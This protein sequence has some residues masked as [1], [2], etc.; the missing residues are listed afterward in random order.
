M[1]QKHPLPA[2]T[3]FSGGSPLPARSVAQRTP[4]CERCV[5][6]QGGHSYADEAGRWREVF[7]GGPSDAF[8][9][10]STLKNDC[11]LCKRSLP[12]VVHR[13]SKIGIIVG[14]QVFPV[15]TTVALLGLGALLVRRAL[16]TSNRRRPIS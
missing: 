15:R 9:K 8:L 12:K 3:P 16:D 5:Q 2:Q 14:M 13:L 1:K 7:G 6:T 11:L 10:K 4:P